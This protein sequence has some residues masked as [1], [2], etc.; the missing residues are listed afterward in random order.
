MAAAIA[1]GRDLHILPT[2][3]AVRVLVLDAHIREEH[4]VVEVRQVVFAG[5]LL[6]LFNRAI[7]TTVAVAI[8]SIA[9]LSNHGKPALDPPSAQWLG[10]HSDRGR[11]RSSALWNSN[12]VDATYDP[13]F[14]DQFE[15]L[16][17]ATAATR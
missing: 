7:R 15:K 12:H 6:N 4:V 8:A 1:L 11:V 16:V 13:A 14:L 3:V 10:R 9:L 5:P 17:L 2:D